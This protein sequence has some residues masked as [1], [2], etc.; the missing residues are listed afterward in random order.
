MRSL[1]IEELE[2]KIREYAL[3]VEYEDHQH[4]RIKLSQFLNFLDS[5]PISKRLLERIQEDFSNLRDSIPEQNN[6]NWRK[7]RREFIES[8]K[9]PD[10]QGAVGY[11]L[12]DNVY[13]SQRIHDTAYVD[14]VYQWY[15]STV[16]YA[17]AKGDFNTFLFIPFVN[18]MYWYISESQSYN[19]ADYFS[20]NEIGIFNEKLE[21]I[22]EEMTKL[23]F[24]QEIIFD[25]I[26]ELKEL[27]MSLK[28]KNWTEILRSKLVDLA[29]GQVLNLETVKK[30]YELITGTDLKI[31]NS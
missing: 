21:D 19:S 2:E 18:L 28:K 23:G 8:I 22:K 16:D 29:I 1:N 3:S 6:Q 10:Q 9:T 12:I 26:Q 30:V 25:E 14:L 5:Q 31:L 11:F 15:E 7:L 17:E 13:R 4:L 20:K 27:L 24:G